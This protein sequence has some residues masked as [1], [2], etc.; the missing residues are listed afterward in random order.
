METPTRVNSMQCVA[1][2]TGITIDEWNKYMEG[3]TK[4]N[5]AII[6]SL[7]K[8]HLPDLYENLA[9]DYRNPYEGSARKK[10]GLLVYV[11]S[12][13]EYFIEFN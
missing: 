2:C 6:R 12:S 11:H 4:A 8:K 10:T 3:T 13:I 1:A 9:L 5:G 7:I